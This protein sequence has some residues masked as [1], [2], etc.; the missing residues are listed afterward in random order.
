MPRVM[1]ISKARASLITAISLFFLGNCDVTYWTDS[2]GHSLIN[3][4]MIIFLKIPLAQV[5]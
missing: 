1:E 3:F 2:I 4:N 5:P